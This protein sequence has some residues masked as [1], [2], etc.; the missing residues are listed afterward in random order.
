MCDD[1][2]IS[3][4]L[5]SRCWSRNRHLGHHEERGGCVPS[6]GETLSPAMLHV[7]SIYLHVAPEDE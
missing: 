6:W 5:Q 2:V 3:D 1:D 4:Q 7:W